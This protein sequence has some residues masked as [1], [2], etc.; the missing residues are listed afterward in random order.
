MRLLAVVEPNLVLGSGM[1]VKGSGC[2]IEVS[3]FRFQGL[4]FTV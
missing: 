4:E 2:R 1:R 3:G